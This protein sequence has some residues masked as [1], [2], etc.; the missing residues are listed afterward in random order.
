MVARMKIGQRIRGALSYNEQKVREGK[1]NLLLT[2]GFAAEAGNIGFTEKLRRFEKLNQRRK[3]VKKNT[4]HFFLS[5]PPEERLEAD[6]L[7]RIAVDYMERIG[8]GG[9]PFLVYQHTDTGNPHVHVVTTSIRSDGTPINL[10]NL[11]KD[12]SEV[13]RKAIEQE[14]GLIPAESRHQKEIGPGD[15]VK[16]KMS[17]EI[18]FITH[19]WRFSNLEELNVLL[20]QKRIVADP[21]KEGSRQAR[22]G[23]L[24]FYR[25]DPDGNKTGVGIKASALSGDPT[26]KN[27]KRKF[28]AGNVRQQTNRPDSGQAL[29]DA[30]DQSSGWAQLH[31]QLAKQGI[32]LSPGRSNAMGQFDGYL[33]NRRQRVIHAVQDLVLP[34]DLLEKLQTLWQQEAAQKELSR[35]VN[36]WKKKQS[37]SSDTH[38]TNPAANS[39]PGIIRTLLSSDP[40]TGGGGPELLPKKKKK[41]RRPPM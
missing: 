36:D 28:A 29:L 16:E 8:F 26:L 13:A 22:H 9:Q 24:V 38:L 23:G 17:S 21:G 15:S 27:L 30:I 10:H 5:F 37:R 35:K 14:Y 6:T 40:A 20:R 19:T 32:V 4:V 2:V 31:R 12:S 7:Q 33:I 3:S 39:L 11:G 1:A 41:R 18:Q 25:L 34:P